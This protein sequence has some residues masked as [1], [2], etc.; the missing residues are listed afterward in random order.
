M[1]VRL[2]IVAEVVLTQDRMFAAEHVEIS[3]GLVTATGRFTRRRKPIGPVVTRTW[4]PTDI[5][6][7]RHTPH[8]AT[9]AS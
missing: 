6:E 8:E 4:G 5:R 3:G 9:D 7:I 2:G 1:T